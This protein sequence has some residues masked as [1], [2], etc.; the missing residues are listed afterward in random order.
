MGE[1]HKSFPGEASG[2]YTDHGID[3]TIDISSGEEGPYSLGQAMYTKSGANDLAEKQAG[4]R[5]HDDGDR[6]PGR[7]TG[8][9][10]RNLDRPASLSPLLGDPRRK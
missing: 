2:G 5:F 1:I 9:N 10:M 6:I 3:N 7:Q 8:L 4:T